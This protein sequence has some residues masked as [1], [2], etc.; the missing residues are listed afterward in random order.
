MGHGMPSASSGLQETIR[1]RPC[2]Q[3][4]AGHGRRVSTG[5]IPSGDDGPRF[6]AAVAGTGRA[7]RT[8]HR[9]ASPRWLS[10]PLARAARVAEMDTGRLSSPIFS[11][12]GIP[13]GL[14]RLT[15][16]ETNADLDTL[17][18]WPAV[19]ISDAQASDRPRPCERGRL[20]EELFVE[21]LIPAVVADEVITGGF[22]AEERSALHRSTG[23]WLAPDCWSHPK[24]RPDLGR[25]SDEGRSGQHSLALCTSG[26]ALLLIDERSGRAVAQ[27]LGLSICRFNSRGHRHWPS[28][29]F[30][31]RQLGPCCP[32]LA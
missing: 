20:A 7:D 16:A 10:S 1:P 19:V 4:Q 17:E 27:G 32:K 12:L 8:G 2:R 23:G 14:I 26:P 31:S 11:R 5:T 21:D 24:R 15:E 29:P 25:I 9:P 6:R 3:F 30:D 28:A 22:P 18:Q 13:T